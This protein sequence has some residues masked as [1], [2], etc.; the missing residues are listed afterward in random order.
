MKHAV[1]RLVLLLCSGAT[2]LA[3]AARDPRKQSDAVDD[4]SEVRV[5]PSRSAILTTQ[6]SS[7]LATDD[8]V[9]N[10]QSADVLPSSQ[11]PSKLS[12]P[13]SDEQTRIM[14]QK[15]K[16][17][18]DDKKL[19]ILII[20]M[21]QLR[22]DYL[23]FI[24]ES[25]PIYK[26]KLKVKTPN[27]DRLAKEGVWFRNAYAQFS[28]CSPARATLRTGCTIERHGID[29]N[30]MLP[31]YMNDPLAKRKVDSARTYDQ[32]LFEQGYQ[33]ESYGKFHLP[34]RWYRNTND[35]QNAIM[36]NSY[37][38][39]MTTPIFVAETRSVDGYRSQVEYWIAQDNITQ[40]RQPGM[41]RNPRSK[42]LYTPLK[43]DPRYG[44]PYRKATSN[45]NVYGVDS[46]PAL[47]SQATY[48]GLQ[49]QLAMQRL[50]QQPKPW[51]LTVS[52]EPPH[53][54]RV[55][56]E[57]YARYYL[58]NKE[59]ILIPPNINNKFDNPWYRKQQEQSMAVGFRNPKR[60][61]E[62]SAIYMGMIEQV[63]N[64]IGVLLDELETQGVANNTLV[65]FTSDHGEF[66][67]AH[68][69]GG[70]MGLMEEALRV[71]FIMR[72]PGK[73]KQGTIVE[74]PVGAHLNLVATLLDYA[75]LSSIDVS[76]GTSLRSLI[77]GRSYNEFYDDDFCVSEDTE[78]SVLGE[79]PN[80]MIRQGDWKLLIAK[81]ADI[82]SPDMLFNLAD[83]P[84]EMD[85]L[86]SRRFL[87]M[88]VTGKVEHLKCLLLEWMSRNDG[89]A[90]K[91]YSSPRNNH[92]Q[93]DGDMQEVTHRRSW[94]E[95][96]QWISDSK[97]TFNPP[98]L[99]DG[100]WRSN[101]F[102][103]I[104]RTTGGTLRVKSISLSGTGQQ[105]F[106]LSQTKGIVKINGHLRIQVS[107]ASESPVD[108]STL[109]VSIVVSS[110]VSTRKVII[111][112][113]AD[114]I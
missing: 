84:Y 22:Y 50:A 2:L 41:Q 105:Y 101:A 35:T 13:L 3:D 104:G 36:Y 81:K 70:K 21:D 100:V 8:G 52:F 40:S 89:G 31:N 91:Y 46:L 25:M 55:A 82:N 49:G 51:I 12:D 68:G 60:L 7:S 58:E 87:S 29:G 19:N 79:F 56:S 64:W 94:N 112:P 103:Y 72:L 80:F 93:G 61:Q 32:L 45:A 20:T 71:P 90:A 78:V 42:N 106:S 38:L 48:T 54:P 113:W 97:L 98:V 65:A 6:R 9:H 88:Q 108:P 27:I 18:P 16:T 75:G 30:Q 73:I 4:E 15:V 5:V 57:E 76:D 62:A 95:V 26:D 28:S 74:R 59:H 24:Q 11:M 43:M 17:L 109:D 14:R 39:E 37:D 92:G 110:N 47:Y 67:G 69:M 77:T 85:N 86:L 1:L 23:Q 44:Q 114:P 63:D 10:G 107:F 53:P 111:V 34:E 66:L 96:R 33:A 83:D 102:L 99:V